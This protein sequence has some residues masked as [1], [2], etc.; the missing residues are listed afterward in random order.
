MFFVLAIVLLSIVVYSNC[1]LGR[2]ALAQAD[3]FLTYENPAFG[4]KM[5]YPH[6]WHRATLQPRPVAMAQ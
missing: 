1:F 4:I 6:D 2:E 5:L 3:D